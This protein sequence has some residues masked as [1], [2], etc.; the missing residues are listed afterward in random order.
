MHYGTQHSEAV[1]W[2][3]AKGGINIKEG[4]AESLPPMDDEGDSDKENQV[5]DFSQRDDKI[6]LKGVVGKAA[7][8]PPGH[9]GTSPMLPEMEEKVSS[10]AET[11]SLQH[12]NRC[13]FCHQMLPHLFRYIFLI[14]KSRH[15]GTVE[16]A[17][18]II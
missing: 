12:D 3:F 8:S 14:K 5:G 4:M 1:K 17:P 7:N 9:A 6:A 2:F 15:Q 18:S 10:G 16:F 11:T 13:P